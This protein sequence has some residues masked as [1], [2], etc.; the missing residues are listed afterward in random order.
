[1]SQNAA[2]NSSY[3]GLLGQEFKFNLDNIVRFHAI[4]KQSK[5]ILDSRNGK[6]YT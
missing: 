1:M 6:Q 3:S 2:N 4:A 5:M